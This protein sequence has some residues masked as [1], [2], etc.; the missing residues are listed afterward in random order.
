MYTGL[1][2]AVVEHNPTI[3]ELVT[4]TLRL[5]HHRV[6]GFLL[7][8]EN[9][10]TL[11]F[12]VVIVEPGPSVRLKPFLCQCETHHVP[13]VIL[14]RYDECYAHALDSRFPV[15][16]MI[17]YGY[18]RALVESIHQLMLFKEQCHERTTKTLTA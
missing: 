1:H 6:S 8:P 11:G 17:F 7:P 18:L 15:I 9:V 13:V 3:L 5:E 10:S 14:T 2:I 4:I 16:S 12:D